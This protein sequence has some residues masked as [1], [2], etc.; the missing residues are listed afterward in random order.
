MKKLVL[1]MA[2]MFAS[3]TLFAQADMNAK[4]MDRDALIKKQVS[5]DRLQVKTSI[6]KKSYAENT[7]SLCDFSDPTAYTFGVTENHSSINTWTL[8]DGTTTVYPDW[9][10]LVYWRSDAGTTETA[11]AT[12]VDGFEPT[13]DIP[14]SVLNGFAGFDLYDVEG[15]DQVEA[16]VKINTPIHTTGEQIDIHLFN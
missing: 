9:W 3:V 14:M 4:K 16:F 15:T 5:L 10:P 6:P 8:L 13:G 11:F 7:F 12:W 2:V 1:A